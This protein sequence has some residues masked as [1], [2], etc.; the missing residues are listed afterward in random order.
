[1][2]KLNMALSHRK[3][4]PY[5]H[6]LVSYTD[7]KKT[8]KKTILVLF[9]KGSFV[10]WWLSVGLVAWRSQVRASLDPIDRSWETLESSSLV[11]VKSRKDNN[12]IGYL[13]DMAEIMLKAS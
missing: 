3:V 13:R 6:L 2:F 1:M 7:K 10:A 12:N 5:M 8:K 4:Y 11:Q 9:G